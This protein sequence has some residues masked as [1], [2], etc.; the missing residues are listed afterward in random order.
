MVVEEIT[1]TWVTGYGEPSLRSELIVSESVSQVVGDSHP[2]VGDSSK[3][4]PTFDTLFG[5]PLGVGVPE[6]GFSKTHL[7][8]PEAELMGAQGDRRSNE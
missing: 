1:P 7:Q 4:D 2:S 3:P 5:H 6:V 8:L